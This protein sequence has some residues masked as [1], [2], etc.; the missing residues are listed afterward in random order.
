[1]AKGGRDDVQ[2]GAGTLP[3]DALTAIG[4]ERRRH[5]DALHTHLARAPE[6]WPL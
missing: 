3:P 1:V 5:H 2:P 6:R 4:D